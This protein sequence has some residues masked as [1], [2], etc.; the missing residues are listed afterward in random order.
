MLQRKEIPFYS[1]K[2]LLL[3]DKVCS[4]PIFKD[5]SC[6]ILRCV[7]RKELKVRIVEDADLIGKLYVLLK[8]V[9]FLSLDFVILQ[10]TF[11]LLFL[12]VT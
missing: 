4:H 7:G 2:H 8:H 5:Y 12:N 6:N 9:C 1:Q 11:K 10:M 3:I